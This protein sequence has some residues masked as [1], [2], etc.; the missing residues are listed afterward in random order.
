MAGLLAAGVVAMSIK[1]LPYGYAYPKQDY[2]QAM[3]YIKKNLEAGD[4]VTVIGITSSFPF[5]EYYRQPWKQIDSV[6]QLRQ[7]RMPGGTVWVIYTFPVYLEESVP[8]LKRQIDDTC[9][10][11]ASFHGTVAGGD[12]SVFRCPPVP[13]GGQ[14]EYR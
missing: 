14:G 13:Q 11:R 3:D 2:V 4:V 6:E 1:S 9:E 5:I 8:D 12:I 10:A 7:A